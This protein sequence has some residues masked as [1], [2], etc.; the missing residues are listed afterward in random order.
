MA[1]SSKLQTLK[2]GSDKVGRSVTIILLWVFDRPSADWYAGVGALKTFYITSEK[3][4]APIEQRH[5]ESEHFE[6][7]LKYIR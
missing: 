4:E 7:S 5:S 2:S 3:H 6:I 1:T